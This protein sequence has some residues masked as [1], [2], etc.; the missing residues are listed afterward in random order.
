MYT[1]TFQNGECWIGGEPDNSKWNEIPDKPIK[2]I[3]YKISDNEIIFENYDAYNHLVERIKT[4]DGRNKIIKI[5]VMAKKDT[6]AYIFE[7]DL[8]K[9][10]VI[11][12]IANFGNEYYGKATTGWKTGIAEGKIYYYSK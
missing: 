3:E 11:S 10:E 6:S 12:R 2:K 5:Y 7:F 1:L 9:R 4:F 8:F